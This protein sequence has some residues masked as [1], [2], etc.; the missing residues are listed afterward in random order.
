MKT[1]EGTS[2][3]VIILSRRFMLIARVVSGMFPERN[4]MLALHDLP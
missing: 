1:N 3:S 2:F 4:K